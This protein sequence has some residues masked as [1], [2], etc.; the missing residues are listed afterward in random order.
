VLL[1]SESPSR[2][3][4]EV[5]PRQYAALVDLMGDV[6]LGRLGEVSQ[7]PGI[8]SGLSPQLTVLG[9]EGLKVI[10]APV[11]KLKEEWQQPLR[12]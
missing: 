9:L 8:T 3:L 6:P 5:A 4:L 12:W 2:F 1:F 10:D 11:S 7:G